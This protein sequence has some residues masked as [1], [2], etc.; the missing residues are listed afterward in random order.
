MTNHL[1]IKNFK[2]IKSLDMPCKRV[3]VFIGEPNSGKSNIVEALALMAQDSLSDGI[4]QEIFRFKTMADFFYDFN[5]SENVE[6]DTDT[7]HLEIKYLKNAN[8]ISLNQFDVVL[9]EI[10]ND[11]PF[12]I[13]S[14]NQTFMYDGRRGDT[15]GGVNTTNKFYEYKRRKNFQPFGFSFLKSPF[16]ENLPQLLVS[17]NKLKKWV[18]DFLRSKG[19]RLQLKPVENEILISKE[20]DDELYSYSYHTISETLQRVIFIYT[21]IETNKDATLLF[22]EPEANTFPFYTKFIAELIGLSE[23]NQFF[24]T[25]HNPYLLTNLIQK[26][27]A[28]ELNLCI[29]EMNNYQTIVHRP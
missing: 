16:G 23:Q 6:V 5:I 29:T 18:S 4:F 17:N 8:G 13:A 3:N 26:T 2:S 14:Y 24:I 15:Q 12:P 9:H 21:A 25:T 28:S 22:D 7:M 11:L 20:V 10:P 1:K 19:Y 27:P